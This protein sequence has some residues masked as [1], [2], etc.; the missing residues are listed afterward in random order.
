MT[1]ND[2]KA[3]LVRRGL[4]GADIARRLG[5]S[6]TLVHDVLHDRRQ[7]AAVRDAIAK[8]IGRPVEEVFAT[9]PVAATAA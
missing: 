7:S 2:R 3:E 9:E 4:T 8:A 1:P 6:R 5:V